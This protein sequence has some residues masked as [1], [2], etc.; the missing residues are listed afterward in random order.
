MNATL[1][2]F[3]LVD[4]IAFA[5][6]LQ[7]SAQ[8]SVDWFKV[9]G[10]SG[11]STGGVYS[12]SGSIG[13]HD[14]GGPM[15]G[16]TYSLKSGFWSVVGVVQPPTPNPPVLHIAF[17]GNTLILSW[18]NSATQFVLESN[19]NLAVTNG[20]SGM[21]PQPVVANGIN[22]VTNAIALGN[23]FYRLRQP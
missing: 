21:S 11:T 23:T 1:K 22:Y 17:E 20:W 5:L 19:S 10:G 9:S 2:T 3:L 4:L 18:T 12:V 15:T 7:S 16:G 14:P 8:F 6:C 13:Q